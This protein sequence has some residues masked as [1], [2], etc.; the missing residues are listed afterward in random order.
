MDFSFSNSSF[1]RTPAALMEELKSSQVSQHINAVGEKTSWQIYVERGRLAGVSH[2]VPLVF[3]Q[4][5]HQLQ[6]LGLKQALATVQRD[7]QLPLKLRFDLLM[8]G[9]EAGDRLLVWLISQGCLTM[10][11]AQQVVEGTTRLALESLLCASEVTCALREQTLDVKTAVSLDIA[12][13]AT[14]ARERLQRW[15]A[16]L[17]AVW[18]PYQRPRLRA[19][20]AEAAPQTGTLSETLKLSLVSILKGGSLRLLAIVLKQDELKVAQFLSTHILSGAIHL[21]DPL[22]TY[23]GL[24]RIAAQDFPPEKTAT[25]APTGQRPPLSPPEISSLSSAKTPVK[26]S[27]NTAIASQPAHCCARLSS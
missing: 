12:A 23:D 27:I 10:P 17:P 22:P 24:P 11:Q 20:A 8:S 9:V 1:S 7:P 18:S 3:Q 25:S 14:T 15:Q 2:D 4:I 26:S 21:D 19:D 6:V 16:F 13:T 5:Q